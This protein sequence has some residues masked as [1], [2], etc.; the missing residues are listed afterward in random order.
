MR[1]GGIIAVSGSPGAR[2]IIT[3]VIND[4]PTIIGIE[5]MIR[6]RMYFCM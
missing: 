1:S 6:L 5:I 2:L 3:K 4:I